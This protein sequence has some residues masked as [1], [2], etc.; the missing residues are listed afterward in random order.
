MNILVTGITGRV[1]RRLSH[2]LVSLGHKVRGLVIPS[3]IAAG[4]ARGIPAEI[5]E[6][7]L[8]DESALARA[9]ADVDA[10][11][12]LA[13]LMSWGDRSRDSELFESN[14]AGTH[15][16]LEA[17]TRRSEPLARFVLAS[18][19]EVYPSL[20]AAYLPIDEE[21]PVRPESF[22]GM[23]KQANEV[24]AR[25]Y[26]RAHGL[27]IAIA[28]FALVTE[29]HEVLGPDGWLGRFLYLDPMLATIASRAGRAAAREVE[30][31]RSGDRTLLLARD[32]EGVPYT[33]HYCDV[34]DLVDGL[35]R[36][37]TNPAAVGE[38][39]N[40]AGPAPFSYDQA[41]GY[42]SERTGYP[43]ADAR[44][45][46]PA[47]HIHH[48]TAKA[49]SLLGYAPRYGIRETIDAAIDDA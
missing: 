43:V 38:A 49:R 30:S 3:D 17:A 14:V 36:L 28:R 5:V 19:D 1:G 13:A 24:M 35:E 32:A 8:G 7:D 6:G 16:L 37:I 34:R 42:L 31:L 48:S 22:Y 21:H 23:T 46:G 44:I 27:S 45:P 47:L 40:L 25:Y 10:V 39:F 33:F 29:P 15:R 12:H 20:G 11:V 41:V 26:Q 9:V 2:H 18:S 4:A